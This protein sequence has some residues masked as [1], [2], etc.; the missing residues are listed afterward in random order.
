MVK[1]I[2][3]SA[4]AITLGFLLI[5]LVME[6]SLRFFPVFT[7]MPVDR[8]SKIYSFKANTTIQRSAHW[9]MSGARKRHVNNVGFISDQDYDASLTSPLIAIIGDSY[10][11]AM[12]VDYVN[13]A[14]AQLRKLCENHVRVYSFGAQF[15]PLSQYLE[16]AQYVATSFRP[17]YLVINIVGNDFDESLIEWQ[18]TSSTGGVPGMTFFDLSKPDNQNTVTIPFAK[19]SIVVQVLRHSA[20]AQYLVRNVEVVNLLNDLKHFSFSS[21]PREPKASGAEVNTQYVGNTEKS[22]DQKRLRESKKAVDLFLN[23]LPEVTGMKPSSILLTI[24]A[25]RPEIYNATSR[26]DLSSYFSV[27]RTYLIKEAKSLG[28]NVEDL[29][30]PMIKNYI[31]NGKRFEFSNDNHWN[32]QGHRVLAESLFNSPPI[33][34]LCR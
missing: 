24:D 32:A 18:K 16:W 15:A 19:E 5:P 13:T 29:R 33:A 6:V 8:E 26:N 3:F 34:A 1:K 12:Q 17:N 11:E 23:R 7:G 28:Y 10:I 4:L 22:F 27:M 25:E 2:I 14:E 20:L 9:D 31:D 30:T 21:K